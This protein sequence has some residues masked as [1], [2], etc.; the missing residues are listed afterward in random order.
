MTAQPFNG[1][2]D[3]LAD[4]G[5]K[6]RDASLADLERWAAERTH[7]FA[8]H[9]YRT[10]RALAAK[11]EIERRGLTKLCQYDDEAILRAVEAEAA[12]LLDEHGP[13][14][15][16]SERRRWASQRACSVVGPVMTAMKGRAN[17]VHVREVAQ[18]VLARGEV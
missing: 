16:R 18:A 5:E 13:F 7:V 14:T 17:P 12:R 3:L 8:G 4:E 11:A 15:S 6:M 2:D 1:P 10:V 9:G